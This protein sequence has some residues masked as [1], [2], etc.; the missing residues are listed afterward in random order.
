MFDQMEEMAAYEARQDEIEA[1][2]ETLEAHRAEFEAL[3]EDLDAAALGA[4]RLF[5][6]ERFRPMRYT[7]DDVHRAFEAV[8]YPQ[9]HKRDPKTYVDIMVRAAQYLAGEEEDQRAHLARQL[10]M[11]LPEYVSAGRYL[12]GWLIQY[13]AFQMVEA[14]EQGNPFLAEMFQHGF[15]EWAEQIDGEQEA[16][17]QELGADRS[18]IE[19]M[20]I[21]EV[22]AWFQEAMADPEKKALV[23]AYYADHPLMSDQAEAEMW[24]RERDALFLLERDDADCL[25]LSPEE[26]DPWMPVLKERLDPLGA[27][28]RQA[29]EQ[30][31]LDD[32]DITEAVGKVLVDISKEMAPAVFTPERIERLMTDLKAY[33]RVLLE[34][35]EGESAMYAHAA[36]RMLEWEDPPAENRMLVAICFASLSVRL[37]EEEED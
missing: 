27:Q 6:E 2:M 1:A 30:G 37:R 8:G 10:M 32:L 29:A 35:G 14:P 28:A 26:V 34:A 9:R 33:R 23:E 7:A 21:D 36:T 11:M 13:S 4:R 20:N 25:Y 15:E 19:G 12:D 5:T 3:A 16:L 31:T 18:G 17:L 24:E 22:E